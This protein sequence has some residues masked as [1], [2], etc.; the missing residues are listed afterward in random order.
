MSKIKKIA[1]WSKFPEWVKEVRQRGVYRAG[2]PEGMY[3]PGLRQLLMLAYRNQLS[4]RNRR[5]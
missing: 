4:Y 2:M 1:V 3:P 5:R